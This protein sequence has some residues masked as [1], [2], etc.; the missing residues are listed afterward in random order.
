MDALTL[1]DKNI[2]LCKLANFSRYSLRFIS[3]YLTLAITIQRLLVVYHPFNIRFKDKRF[4]WRSIGLIFLIGLVL[5]AVVP[6]FFC[7]NQKESNE[8]DVYCDVNKNTKLEYLLLNLNYSL[9]IIIIPSIVILVSNC[10]IIYKTNKQNSLR[11][12]LN[13]S[14]RFRKTS[15][16][17]MSVR[18]EINLLALKSLGTGNLK[19]KSSLSCDALKMSSNL[20]EQVIQKNENF[21]NSRSNPNY[22]LTPLIAEINQQKAD[23]S[24]T[25][26]RI[27][28]HYFTKEQLIMKNT[29][30]LS[31][32]HFTTMLLVISFS[33]VCL[34][35]PYFIFWLLFFYDSAFFQND[36]VIQNN[37]FSALQ[38]AEI[39]FVLNYAALFIILLATGSLFKSQLKTMGIFF[40]DLC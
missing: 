24:P 14:S 36:R 8:L 7:I 37:L 21:K 28:P 13:E 22:K 16:L 10:L 4:A 20:K 11:K 39:F 29:K 3:A 33:F 23:S 38:I 25:Q 5:N 35:T 31:Q 30:K 32:K 34:N 18:S 15:F 19:L 17:K 26:T 12:T 40:F 6:F 27:K 1:V 2:G 9:I